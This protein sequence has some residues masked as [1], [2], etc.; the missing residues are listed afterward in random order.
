M[1]FMYG[2]SSVWPLICM[3]IVWLGLI[4]LGCFLV[5]NFNHGQRNVKKVLKERFVR[6]EIDEKKYERLKSILKK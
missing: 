1:H 3:I 5:K 4:I 6:G 2:Y